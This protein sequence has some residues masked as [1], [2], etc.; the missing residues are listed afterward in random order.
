MSVHEVKCVKLT[1]FLPHPDPETTSLEIVK[2]WGYE[3]IVKK[4]DFKVGDLGLFIEPDYMVP[5]S[6]PLFTF[7]A[8]D[9]TDLKP[10]RITTK[11]LRKVWSQ[12]LLV[13]ALPHHKEGDNVM[14]E[15]GITR[16]EPI[17]KNAPT[18]GGGSLLGGA[19]PKKAPTLPV[20]KIPSYDLEN[21][22]KHSHL[23]TDGVDEVIAT[24]KYHGAS[25]RYVVDSDGEF[26]VGSRTVWKHKPGTVLRTVTVT[27]TKKPPHPKGFANHYTFLRKMKAFMV[28][29]VQLLI[30]LLTKKTTTKDVLAPQCSWWT[31]A[32]DNPWIEK[33]CR[34]HPNC[35]V[36]G[37]IF[38][39]TIQGKDFHYGHKNGKV[40]F[41]VFDVLTEDGKW[42]NCFDLHHG[43]DFQ[44]L[45]KVMRVYEG[46]MDRKLLETIAEQTE[47]F[48]PFGE[49]SGHIREGVVIKRRTEDQTS[50]VALKLVS[51]N[52]LLKS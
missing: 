39:D 27:E 29:Y 32:A 5:T 2:V 8:K 23:L 24:V 3:V 17:M 1:E 45:L 43:V 28:Y 14:E 34:E 18:S 49:K 26:H 36:Y 41:R 50:R 46:P 16:W 15:L 30:W 52:Y 33:W 13:K 4:G 21:Y 6:N 7:L 42:V 31:A 20:G 35:V 47:D 48:N 10:V 44:P 25:A 38:G 22:K 40:G 12:G 11:R 19:P 37:E 51:N 9:P